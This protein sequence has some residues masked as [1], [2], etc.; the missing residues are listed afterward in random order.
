LKTIIPHS[1]AY[2]STRDE[3]ASLVHITAEQIKSYL[4]QTLDEAPRPQWGCPGGWGAYLGGA[5]G[6]C[7]QLLGSSLH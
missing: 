2:I 3:G 5:P 4:E 7:A 1:T 6:T